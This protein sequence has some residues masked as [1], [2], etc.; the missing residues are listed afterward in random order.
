MGRRDIV[1]NTL[2][3]LIDIRRTGKVL[4]WSLPQVITSFY[5]TLL[6]CSFFFFSLLP[7]NFIYP[8]EKRKVKKDR[9]LTQLKIR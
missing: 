2:L 3:Y 5:L 4:P 8:C 6:F 9:H 1:V 7:S